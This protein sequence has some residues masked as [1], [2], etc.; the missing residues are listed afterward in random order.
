MCALLGLKSR[1]VTQN[2]LDLWTQ[3]LTKGGL[4]LLRNYR[5]G[6]I[7]PNKQDPFSEMV[8]QPD[9]GELSGP[10]L[11]ARVTKRPLLPGHVYFL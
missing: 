8:L 4:L 10:L 2:I 7:A 1:R 6:I 3:E 9:F 5:S 11:K